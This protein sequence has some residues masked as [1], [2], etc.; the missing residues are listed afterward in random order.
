MNVMLAH[1]CANKFAYGGSVYPHIGE[2][3]KH[4]N[5]SFSTTRLSYMLLQGILQKIL[6]TRLHVFVGEKTFSEGK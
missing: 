3:K 6:S 5:N 1:Y 4:S 2:P